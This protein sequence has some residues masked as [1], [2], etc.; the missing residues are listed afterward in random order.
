MDRKTKKEKFFKKVLKMKD[1]DHTIVDTPVDNL[2]NNYL[3]RL[4]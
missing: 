1:I 3:S 2:V 4:N